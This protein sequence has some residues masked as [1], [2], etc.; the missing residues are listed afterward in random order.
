ME[1]RRGD[2]RRLLGGRG[3]R[4]KRQ[5]KREVALVGGD[6]YADLARQDREDIKVPE[7][8]SHRRSKDKWHRYY[9]NFEYPAGTES[10]RNT[11]QT[12]R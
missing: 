5:G 8:P 2:R 10:W 3:Q 6:R 9:E 4:K 11:S 1:D 7:R 12:A